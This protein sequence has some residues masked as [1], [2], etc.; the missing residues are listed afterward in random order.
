MPSIELWPNMTARMSDFRKKPPRLEQ[1]FA[2]YDPALY[3]VTMVT[4]QRQPLLA[5]DLAH[6]AF[7]EHAIQQARIGVGVGRYVIMP[8]HVHF[9]V[10]F[11]PAHTLGESVKHL[12]QA[13]TKALRREQSV[14]R[15]WQ[16]GFFDHLLRSG[17]SYGQ[18]WAYVRE[19]PV[20][21]GLVCQADDWPYQGE[22]V[23]IDR[24]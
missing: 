5:S 3:F 20:R 22:V 1:V 19:N 7:R 12:K 21:A 10:R 24:V 6:F 14:A 15:V 16:P 11:G 17:E 18:K 23:H 13:V 9:F 4:W 8:D 2:H